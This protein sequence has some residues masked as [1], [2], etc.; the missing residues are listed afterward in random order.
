MKIVLSKDFVKQAKHLKPGEREKLQQRLKV[1]A[2]TP[3]AKEL[4]N[5][6]LQ[7]EWSNYRSINITGDIRAV[8][9]EIED[10]AR[11]VAIGTHAKLYR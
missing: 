7:G 2:S 10:G 6:K 1:F 11:F 4:R 3:R 9:E 5:H 8:Y